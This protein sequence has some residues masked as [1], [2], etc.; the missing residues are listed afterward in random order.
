MPPLRHSLPLFIHGQPALGHC[1]SPTHSTAEGYLAW[2][3]ALALELNCSGR[4]GE[5]EGKGLNGHLLLNGPI[6]M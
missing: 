3:H 5:T 4:E 2:L 1:S 6:Q